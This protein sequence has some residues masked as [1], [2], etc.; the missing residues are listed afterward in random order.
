ML[1]ISADVSA[2]SDVQREALAGFIRT[3]PQNNAPADEIESSPEKAFTPL[4]AEVA[5]T[6][7]GPQLVAQTAPGSL[8]KAGLPWDERIHSSSKALTVDGLWRKK[9]GVDDAAVAT[10]EAQLKQL[11]SLPT[12][13][14]LEV[15]PA[16]SIAAEVP[17]PPPPAPVVTDSR[18]AF[19]N[20]VGRVSAAVPQNKITLEEVQKACNDAGVPSLPLLANRP[21]LI[22][23]VALTIEALIASR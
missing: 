7:P 14:P 18:Q 16:V 1:T 19:V 20:L 17:P 22:P 10:V 9:R 5:D 11:M 21:D 8:D 12:P 23:Q 4:P 3:F 2:L 13:A 6:Q 15:I